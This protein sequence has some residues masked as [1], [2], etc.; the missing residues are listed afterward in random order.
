MYESKIKTLLLAHPS[1]QIKLG[2][3]IRG[4]WIV[5][6]LLYYLFVQLSTNC[7]NTNKITYYH[8]SVKIEIFLVES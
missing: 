3:G 7:L 5:K 2:K 6:S 4:I 1:F 8:F